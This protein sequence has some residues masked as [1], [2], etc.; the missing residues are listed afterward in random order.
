[1][2]DQAVS[3]L[4][5]QPDDEEQVVRIEVVNRPGESGDKLCLKEL[6]ERLKYISNEHPALVIAA[7]KLKRS[8]GIR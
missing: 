6:R 3:K 1:M 8:P 5:H 2:D 7:G 4:L